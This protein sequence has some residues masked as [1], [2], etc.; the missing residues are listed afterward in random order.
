MWNSNG[1]HTGEKA[2]SRAWEGRAGAR[3]R[4]PGRW[5]LRAGRGVVVAGAVGT[6]FAR[7]RVGERR[8]DSDSVVHYQADSKASAAPP[9]AQRAAT[10]SPPVASGHPH[11]RRQRRNQYV[12]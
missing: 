2:E 9:M 10:R 8:A 1:G 11:R 5:H 4:R 6:A 7:Y 12:E 3:G